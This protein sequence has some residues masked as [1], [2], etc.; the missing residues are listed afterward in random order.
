[1][2][3][4]RCSRSCQNLRVSMQLEL[5][6]LVAKQIRA[7]ARCGT[8]AGHLHRRPT[9]PPGRTPASRGIGAR[10]RPPRIPAHQLAPG[11]LRL[12]LKTCALRP[13]VDVKSS[14]GQTAIRGGPCDLFNHLVA[15]RPCG[16][17]RTLPSETKLDVCSESDSENLKLSMCYPLFIATDMRTWVFVRVRAIS[18]PHQSFPSGHAQLLT[19][20]SFSP[21]YWLLRAQSQ[22][23]GS[24]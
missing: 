18:W 1:M 17:I 9:A 12:R 5:V 19:W 6:L 15:A 14:I 2:I 23:P 13:D 22:S 11:G 8:A 21:T 7:A 24:S 4:V 3:R 20:I 10:A 16:D